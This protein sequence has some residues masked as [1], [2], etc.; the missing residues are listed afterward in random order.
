MEN[1][2]I[3]KIYDHSFADVKSSSYTNEPKYI[4]WY[5]GNDY[6]EIS[7]FTD[8]DLFKVDESD[9]KIKIAWL[10]EPKSIFPQSYDF[11]KVNYNKF[12]KILTYDKDLLALNNKFVFYPHGGSWIKEEDFK[13]YGKSKMCSIISSAK[14]QTEGQRLRH[15]VVKSYK[16]QIEVM[17]H[18]YRSIDSK[19]EGLCD[20]RYSII[21][22]NIKQDWY[23][24]EK[25]IDCLSV[26]CVPIYY[27]TEKIDRFFDKRGIIQFDTIDDLHHVLNNIISEEDYNS[28]IEYIKSN[29]E[30]C[31]KYRVAEDWIYLNF[32]KDFIK[33]LK[34]G[35]G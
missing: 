15:A 4:Q 31:K 19:K 10:I 35:N 9:S 14:N 17:G 32:L 28:R 20:Y 24:T 33:G 34:N 13:V 26:G 11:V 6:H 5:R 30:E 1:K 27:G 12:D 16:D 21:I 7:F 25:L 8:M 29:L 18:G 23:F 2:I 22:E 3:V